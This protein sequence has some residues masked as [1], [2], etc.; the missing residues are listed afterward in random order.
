MKKI[1]VILTKPSDKEF[2]VDTVLTA[3]QLKS[4]AEMMEIRSSHPLIQN[5]TAIKGDNDFEFN[6]TVETESAYNTFV[7][8][9]LDNN[10]YYQ[11]Y[12][13]Y[14]TANGITESVTVADVA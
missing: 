10:T 12:K 14:N 7:S 13:A 2:L 1:T 6:Y 5:F 4:L 3:T 8:Y 11:D 9:L